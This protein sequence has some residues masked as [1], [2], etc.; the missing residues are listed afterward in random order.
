M[1]NV[2]ECEWRTEPD[3]IVLAGMIYFSLKDKCKC[4]EDN[5]DHVGWRERSDTTE[6]KQDVFNVQA[7]PLS[8]LDGWK[9]R[10]YRKSVLKIHRNVKYKSH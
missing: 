8:A 1:L 9:A 6:S 2:N 10:T 7:G 3:V 4:E 5:E